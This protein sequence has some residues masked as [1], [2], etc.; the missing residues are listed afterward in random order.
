ME[1]EQNRGDGKLISQAR[2][3]IEK[4]QKEAAERQ[5]RE[6]L[7]STIDKTNLANKTE[8]DH[9]GARQGKGRDSLGH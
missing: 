6:T 2:Q 8:Q 1:N 4:M 9:K 3:D 7:R 5:K